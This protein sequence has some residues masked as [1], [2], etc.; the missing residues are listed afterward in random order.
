MAAFE[1]KFPSF[2][3]IY[4]RNGVDTLSLMPELRKRILDESMEWDYLPF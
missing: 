3:I 1:E 2:G 4:R